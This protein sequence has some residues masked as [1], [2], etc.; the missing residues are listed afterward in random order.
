MSYMSNIKELCPSCNAPL[1]YTVTKDG[2][3]TFKVCLDCT[4]RVLVEPVAKK[5]SL[6]GLC[7]VIAPDQ[8][9]PV[10]KYE[11][12]HP[13][14]RMRVIS[15]RWATLGRINAMSALPIDASRKEVKLS[16]IVDGLVEQKADSESLQWHGNI[17]SDDAIAAF[18]KLSSQTGAALS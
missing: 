16:E 1:D 13:T 6:S 12:L 14:T 17:S 7:Y 10:F 5:G 3:F 18:S 11:L 8:L 9:V 2:D 4:M 15:Q